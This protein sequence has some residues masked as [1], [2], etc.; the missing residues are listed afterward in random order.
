MDIL[1]K[2]K[3]Q[4]PQESQ[5]KKPSSPLMDEYGHEY[6]A[7]ERLAIRVSGG[8]I[9]T[10]RQASYALLGVMGVVLLL[11]LLLFFGVPDIGQRTIPLPCSLHP[12]ACKQ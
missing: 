3:E 7:M 1:Q 2:Y 8:R 6:S 4:Y 11:S 5:E 9:K 12:T 10:G